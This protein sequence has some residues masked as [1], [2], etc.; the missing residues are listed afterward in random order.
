M[1]L[2]YEKCSS[3]I[4]Q[5]ESADHECMQMFV[6]LMDFDFAKLTLSDRP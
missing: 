4:N 6:L 3:E 1:S 5:F 2:D